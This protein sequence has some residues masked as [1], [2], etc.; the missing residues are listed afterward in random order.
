MVSNAARPNI[1][2]VGTKLLYPNGQ[3]QHAGVLI[4]Y[5]GVADHCFKFSERDDFS[6]FEENKESN[7]ELCSD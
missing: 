2:C 7:S 1:G 5:G 4:G 6:W 3:I